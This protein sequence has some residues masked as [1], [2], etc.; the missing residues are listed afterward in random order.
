MSYTDFESSD[1]AIE[2]M[3]GQ[4]LMNK[5]ITEMQ[6][7]LAERLVAA[8]FTAAVKEWDV[9]FESMDGGRV[10]TSVSNERA[11]E[12]VANWLDDL[13]LDSGERVTPAEKTTHPRIMSSRTHI[14]D[15]ALGAVGET[16]LVRLDRIA[17]HEGLQCNLRAYAL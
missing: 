5:P 17:E 15:N 1:A 11:A 7:M 2:S 4:F 8:N 6:I 13:H 3:N 10:T 14:S 12:E 16:P 9:V